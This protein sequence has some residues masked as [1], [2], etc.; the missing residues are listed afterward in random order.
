MG[1]GILWLPISRGILLI[2]GGS[3]HGIAVVPAF[4]TSRLHIRFYSSERMTNNV[5]E[6][7]QWPL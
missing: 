2:S 1:N 6:N 5:S 7:I 4:R 3:E